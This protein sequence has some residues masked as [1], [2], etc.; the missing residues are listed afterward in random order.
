MIMGK[1][2]SRRNLSQCPDLVLLRPSLSGLGSEVAESKIMLVPETAKLREDGDEP[3]LLGFTRYMVHMGL[4][5]ILG[6]IWHGV[7]SNWRD[8]YFLVFTRPRH[9]SLIFLWQHQCSEIGNL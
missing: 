7:R 2:G 6:W 5:R 9:I 3:K 4:A 8:I 1:K